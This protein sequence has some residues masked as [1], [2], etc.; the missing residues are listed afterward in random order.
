MPFLA[1]VLSTVVAAKA[2]PTIVHTNTSPFCTE[3]REKTGVVIAG[4][5]ANDRLIAHAKSTVDK[6]AHDLRGGTMSSSYN[7]THAARVSSYNPR[8]QLDNQALT[9]DASQIQSNLSTIDSLLKGVKA[10]YI[11]SELQSVRDAQAKNLNIFGAMSQ[12][13]DMENL[14]STGDP[15]NGM[16]GDT[17]NGMSSTNSALSSGDLLDDL[18]AQHADALGAAQNFKT[19]QQT[20]AKGAASAS[21]ASLAQ[22][23]LLE[24]IA[25]QEDATAKSDQFLAESPFL[26]LY[27][28]VTLN[29]AATKA[30]EQPLAIVVMNAAAQCAQPR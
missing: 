15:L 22:R 29:Q 9:M 6:M 30:D 17:E 4:L 11:R 23:R 16:V 18:S 26:D 3:L 24:S 13:Y 28:A 2:P 27:D 12:T 25:A 1:L 7:S 20:G 10:G 21:A 14:A 19:A 5:I 8:M